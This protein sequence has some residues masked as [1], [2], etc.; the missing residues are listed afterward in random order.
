MLSWWGWLTGV[1]VIAAVVMLRWV[2]LDL[3][4]DRFNAPA[5]RWPVKRDR[6][7]G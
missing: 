6:L 5:T 2:L 3:V 4:L 7:P 1:A